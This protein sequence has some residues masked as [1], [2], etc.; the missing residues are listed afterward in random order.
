ML[1]LWAIL[2]VGTTREYLL[3]YGF[4]EAFIYDYIK[5]KSD[6]TGLSS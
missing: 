1:E 3:Q 6:Y 5:F 2:T 4:Y